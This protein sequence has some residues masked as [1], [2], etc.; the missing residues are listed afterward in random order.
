MSQILN[1]KEDDLRVYPLTSTLYCMGKSTFVEGIFLVDFQ[2]KFMV[3]SVCKIS[4][5]VVVFF[6]YFFIF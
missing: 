2:K 1:A 3:Q 4:K 5:V 6:Y